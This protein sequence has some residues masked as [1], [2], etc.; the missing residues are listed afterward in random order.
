MLLT[1]KDSETDTLF[2]ELVATEEFTGSHVLKVPPT[3]DVA[4]ENG[5]VRESRNKAK[6]FTTLNGRTVV[7]KESYVYSNKGW[8]T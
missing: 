2:T 4:K 3:T 8:Q 7:I 5:N 6:Q 1:N